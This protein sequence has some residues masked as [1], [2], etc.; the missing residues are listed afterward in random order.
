MRLL[1]QRL[2]GQDCR[3]NGWILH[4]A[5][6]NMDQITMMKEFDTQVPI[7]I[8]YM[9]MSDHLIYEKLGQRRFDPVTN[10]YHYVLDENIK[11]PVILDRLQL[12][13]EDEH[14]RFKAKI[15]EFRAFMQQVVPEFPPHQL[16]RINAEQPVRDIHKNF[17]EAI[18]QTF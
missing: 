7:L 8:I 3:T 11:D 15:Q 1:R 17:Q 4:G 9:E 5:P 18:E 16:V 12:K 6:S 14:K 2:D 13:F 10:K